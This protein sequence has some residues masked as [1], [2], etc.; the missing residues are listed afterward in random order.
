MD[1]LLSLE[2]VPPQEQEMPF[3]TM[4]SYCGRMRRCKRQTNRVHISISVGSTGFVDRLIALS[5]STKAFFIITRNTRVPS[6]TLLR[7][8]WTGITS[9]GPKSYLRQSSH[10]RVHLRQL[11]KR[12]PLSGY[13]KDD[14]KKHKP[15]YI[16]QM[17]SVRINRWFTTILEMSLSTRD[18]LRRR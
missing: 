10:G 15:C 18:S 4:K 7:F 11:I 9:P 16:A 17:N 2:A 14:L 5:P 6:T 12:S 1:D 3:G 8:I 13:A